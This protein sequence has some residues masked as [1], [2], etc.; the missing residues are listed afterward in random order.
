MANAHEYAKANSAQFEKQLDDLLR[1]KSISTLPECKPDVQ[2]AAE[3]V[4][5]DMK[6]IGLTTVEILP[7][8]GHPVVYG[9]WL[10]YGASGVERLRRE[11]TI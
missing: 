1:I 6:R 5:A 4:A 9:E 3:W 11:G 7:T 2:K 10:G 8:D